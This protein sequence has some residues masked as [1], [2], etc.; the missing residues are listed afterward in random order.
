MMEQLSE[1]NSATVFATD[2]ILSM[3]MCATRSVYPW[4]IVV[5]RDGDKLY[6]DKRP[7]SAFGTP[8]HNAGIGEMY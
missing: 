6:F 2:S 7:D 5:V 4:D 1:S 8:P 3:M